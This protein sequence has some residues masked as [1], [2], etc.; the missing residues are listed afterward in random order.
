MARKNRFNKLTEIPDKEEF[1]RL[2]DGLSYVK[3]GVEQL[4]EIIKDNGLTNKF[5]SVIL[6]SSGSTESTV[7]TAIGIR[8]DKGNVIDEHP[9][10]F[11]YDKNDPSKNFGGIIHHGDW[12][13]RTTPL[14]QTEIN[15]LSASGITANFSYKN[16]PPGTSG[17]L[18]DLN[19]NNM[20][21]GV[22]KQ[23]SILLRN[24][25]EDE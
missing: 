4:P 7:Y 2:V 16:I 1:E 8:P 5:N 22:S 25:E 6:C 18:Y 20:L 9:F 21:E 19:E 13:D 24:K 10:V 23:F 11:H 15:A 14:N 17:S 3:L 12:P